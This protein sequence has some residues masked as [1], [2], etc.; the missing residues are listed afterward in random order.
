MENLHL[1]ILKQDLSNNISLLLYF[2]EV[3]MNE[4]LLKI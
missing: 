2:F 4:C 3:K 1:K